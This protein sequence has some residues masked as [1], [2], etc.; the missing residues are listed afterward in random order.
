MPLAALL[1]SVLISMMLSVSIIPLKHAKE[2]QRKNGAFDSATGTFSDI[3]GKTAS[4]SETGF[5]DLDL[6]DRLENIE[7]AMI[8]T[9]RAVSTLSHANGCADWNRASNIWSFVGGIGGVGSLD[10]VS[11]GATQAVFSCGNEADFGRGLFQQSVP[12]N[13]V[14]GKGYYFD[15]TDISDNNY[16]PCGYINIVRL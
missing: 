2:L 12:S 8:R 13:Y 7:T 5:D 1:I 11:T 3:R 9:C 16:D 15:F 4:L 14:V 10:S 6:K